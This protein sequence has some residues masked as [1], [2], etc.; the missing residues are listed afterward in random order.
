MSAARLKE[1]WGFGLIELTRH[2]ARLSGGGRGC[3]RWQV[4]ELRFEAI[5]SVSKSFCLGL[6]P[7]APWWASRPV[8]RLSHRR[9]WGVERNARFSH[10]ESLRC[11]QW[12][13]GALYHVMSCGDASG[14]R[15]PS[16]PRSSASIAIPSTCAK[17]R[18]A[19]SLRLTG[20]RPWSKRVPSPPEA[21]DRPVPDASFDRSPNGR[22][23]SRELL[24]A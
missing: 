19:S 21:V 18:S 12:Y 13:P 1:N 9:G 17:A 20:F 6:L 10:N 16:R 24:K 15:R 14:W 11:L 23:L 8:F 4:A 7:H 22:A 2:A 3:Q 5:R